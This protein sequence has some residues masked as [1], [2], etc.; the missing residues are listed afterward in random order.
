MLN[1]TNAFFT[2]RI[3]GDYR[4][5]NPK[6]SIFTLN[7]RT[8]TKALRLTSCGAHGYLKSSDDTA[9]DTRI[10]PHYGVPGE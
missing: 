9:N 7:S 3:P 5:L 4:F 1:F 8:F 6:I 10:S 2:G